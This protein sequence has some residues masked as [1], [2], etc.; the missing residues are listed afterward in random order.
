MRE[1]KAVVLDENDLFRDHKDIKL[2][3]V[4]YEHFL[5]GRRFAAENELV[6]FTTKDGRTKIIKDRLGDRGVSLYAKKRKNG[7]NKDTGRNKG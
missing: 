3:D 5:M 7:K 4:G 6:V 1:L 2:E